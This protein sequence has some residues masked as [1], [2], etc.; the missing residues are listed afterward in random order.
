VRSRDDAHRVA[1]IGALEDL[2]DGV[3]LARDHVRQRRGDALARR[4]QRLLERRVE[5]RISAS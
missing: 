2:A 3:A 4:G 1:R 5:C